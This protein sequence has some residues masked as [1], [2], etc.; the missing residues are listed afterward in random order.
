LVLTP[1]R[2]LANQVC[3][4]VEKLGKYLGFNTLAIYGGTSYE[5]QKRRLKK[6]KPS[7]IVGTPGRVIVLMEQE[8]P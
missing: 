2:E 7:I 3:V 8:L 4:E 1:T 6:D 5:N